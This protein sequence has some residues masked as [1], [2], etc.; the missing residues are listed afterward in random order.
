MIPN[1]EETC[2]CQNGKEGE[3]EAGS[4]SPQ[5]AVRREMDRTGAL[6]VGELMA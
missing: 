3:R 5:C 2:H 1:R 4:A 6:L